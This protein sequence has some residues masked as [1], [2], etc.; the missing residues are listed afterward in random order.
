MKM[1]KKTNEQRNVE[2]IHNTGTET[3]VCIKMKYY[4][5]NTHIETENEHVCTYSRRA[6]WIDTVIN[7]RKRTIDGHVNGLL[8]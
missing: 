2:S 1:M 7:E 6:I 3:F 8:D 5:T 4:N